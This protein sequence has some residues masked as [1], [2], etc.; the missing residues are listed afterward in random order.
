MLHL[1][2]RFLQKLRSAFTVAP[3]KYDAEASFWR[4]EISRYVAWYKGEMTLYGVSPPNSDQKATDFGQ[5]LDAIET[6]LKLHQL[7]KYPS[8]LSLRPD[9]LTG[10]RVLD[11]GCG[12]FPGLRAFSGCAMRVGV[13]PLLTTYAKIGFPL[14][15]WSDG[16]IYCQPGRRRCLSPRTVSTPF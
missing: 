11:I 3:D 1:T 7:P 5:P 10:L 14:A 13:D 4:V 15:R 16:Y 9:A 12:P 6:W 8:N 2:R